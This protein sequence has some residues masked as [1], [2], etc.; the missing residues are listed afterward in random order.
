MKVISITIV[1]QVTDS[2]AVID[3]VNAAVTKRLSKL[4]TADTAREACKKGFAVLCENMDACVRVSDMVAPEHLEIQTEDSEVL[5]SDVL[6]SKSLSES[7]ENGQSLWRLI[8][9][10]IRSRSVR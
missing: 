9:R 6:P 4:S 10:E 8:C 3:E 2:S 1:V 7:R 5:N